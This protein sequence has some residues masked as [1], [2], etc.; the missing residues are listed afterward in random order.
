MNAIARALGDTSGLLL[1]AGT[2]L[3]FEAGVRLQRLLGG[4]AIANPVLVAV[5]LM[6]AVVKLTGTSGAAYMTAVRPLDLLLGPATV[7]LA[8]PL[9][10]SA[11]RI[12]QA[13]MPV[14]LGC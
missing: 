10:R 1:L 7:A 4:T 12:R 6:G 11:S 13:I 14:M 2:L 8:L 9:Y 5:V 3:A